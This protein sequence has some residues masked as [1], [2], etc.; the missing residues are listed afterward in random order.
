MRGSTNPM[1]TLGAQQLKSQYGSTRIKDK[2]QELVRLARDLVEITIEIVTDKFKANTMIEMSQT[3]L[4]TNRQVEEQLKQLMQQAQQAAM[5]P[6]GQQMMQQQPEQVQQIQQQVMSQVGKLKKQPTIEQVM[7]LVKDQRARAFTFDIETDSTIQADEQAEKQQRNEFTAVLAQ[8]LPQLAQ[9]IASEPKTADFCGEILKFTTAPYRAGRSLESAIDGLVEQMKQKGDQP[10]GDDPTTAANKVT[11]QV[12][13]MKVQQKDKSDQETMKLQREEMQM[14]DKQHAATLENQRRIEMAKLQA[15][16]QDDEA[17]A[18]LQ[19]Q[20]M[21]HEGEKHQIKMIES[22]ANLD[23]TRQKLE[24]AKE[25]QQM[26][27]QDMV[28]KQNERQQMLS[29][30]QQQATATKG[31]VP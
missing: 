6:Q 14:K 30:K 4:P 28:A 25:Q 23:A 5:S 27:S 13:T 20:K 22:E 2:Q 7:K 15:A 29:F 11:L 10:A 24:L 17:K 31:I 12:E 3:E 19:N 8:L 21:M 26:K 1:E 16:G 18:G 9:M